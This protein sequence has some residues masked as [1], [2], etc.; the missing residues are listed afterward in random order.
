MGLGKVEVEVEVEVADNRLS[1][2]KTDDALSRFWFFRPCARR[3]ETPK[4]YSIAPETSTIDRSRCTSAF[5][6]LFGFTPGWRK[7]TKS[8][9]SKSSSQG[10]KSSMLPHAMETGSR[11]HAKGP[12]GRPL[13][14]G[15]NCTCTY[16]STLTSPK[17]LN[18]TKPRSP[19]EQQPGQQTIATMR[20]CLVLRNPKPCKP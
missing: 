11:W 19:K 9:K 4:L 20:N 8:S 15:T 5:L 1:G 7:S 10:S 17:T 3:T 14:S 6:F 18:R 16:V 2:F 12:A 13:P